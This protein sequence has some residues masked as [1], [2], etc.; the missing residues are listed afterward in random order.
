MNFNNEYVS[1]II[2]VIDNKVKITGNSK[3]N[4][5]VE[6]VAAIVAAVFQAD[7]AGVV[8]P[9]TPANQEVG[10]VKAMAGPAPTNVVQKFAEQ[11]AQCL[12]R[13]DCAEREGHS[14]AEMT[15]VEDQKG[16]FA[17]VEPYLL[18]SCKEVCIR[19]NDD[20]YITQYNC[21]VVHKESI[22]DL[23]L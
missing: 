9:Y 5:V 14:R 15:Q 8:G 10:M 3:E 19:G 1:A 22:I 18:L 2:K 20:D 21:N 6:I 4:Y 12:H 7:T 16:D 11:R 17:S 13:C 23:L